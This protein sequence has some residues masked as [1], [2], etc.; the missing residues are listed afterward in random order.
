MM[1]TNDYMQESRLRIDKFIAGLPKCPKCGAVIL[2]SQ[3]ECACEARARAEGVKEAQRRE[4]DIKRLGGRLA[5]ER[6][7]LSKFSDQQALNLCSRYPDDNLYICGSSGTGKTHLATALIRQFEDGTVMRASSFMR[8]SRMSN[9]DIIMAHKLTD[10][11]VNCR[12]MVIDDLDADTR[13]VYG[14][15][16]LREILTEREMNMTGGLIIT[17]SFNLSELANRF[18]DDRITSRIAGLCKF[19]GLHNEDMRLKMRGE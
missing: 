8:L 13:T 6:F 10:K 9:E 12:H 17:S 15:G 5:Y 1:N 2:P 14:L 16:L 3:A 11:A 4:I 19:V 7:T 18:G